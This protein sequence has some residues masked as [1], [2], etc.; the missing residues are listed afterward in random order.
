MSK[1]EKTGFEYR[2][3]FLQRNERSFR[4]W[5]SD[6]AFTTLDRINAGEDVHDDSLR[7]LRSNGFRG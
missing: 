7:T 5:D 3:Q 1:A 6:P 4:K 2:D